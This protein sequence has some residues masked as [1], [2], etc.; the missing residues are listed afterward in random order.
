MD[1]N[2]VTLAFKRPIPI[3]EDDLQVKLEKIGYKVPSSNHIVVKVS[4]DGMETLSKRWV[5]DNS[6][7]Y[8]DPRRGF[9]SSEGRDIEKTSIGFTDIL[10]VSKEYFD[11]FDNE[12]K[13]AELNF[14]CRCI[15]T[16]APLT[17]LK[18]AVR[19]T[20]HDEVGEI[21]NAPVNPYTLEIF[22]ADENEL[23]K[24]LN[25]VTNWQ[26]ITIRPIVINPRYYQVNIVYRQKDVE[27]VENCAKT[28]EDIV[29]KLIS[30]IEGE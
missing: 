1:R 8:Y 23:D 14:S 18:Q 13:W 3:P 12:L 17:A 28:V 4:S 22:S 24:A 16:K 15:G 29:N 26:H 19:G 25:E 20:I 11:D 5:K 7:V 27:K 21:I 10:K 30:H 9:L 6:D 2:T